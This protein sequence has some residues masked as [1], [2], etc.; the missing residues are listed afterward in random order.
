MLRNIS[1][2]ACHGS[3][4]F[5]SPMGP[6]FGGRISV[7]AVTCC[8]VPFHGLVRSRM[9]ICKNIDQMAEIQRTPRT[10]PLLSRQVPQRI[11]QFQRQRQRARDDAALFTR[12][13]HRPYPRHST[14]CCANA[15]CVLDLSGLVS[16]TMNPLLARQELVRGMLGRLSIRCEPTGIASCG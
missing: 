7:D 2:P 1:L 8:E 4:T 9:A 10:P 6:N 11:F 14:R 13:R 16:A 3:K 12:P 15:P 5:A